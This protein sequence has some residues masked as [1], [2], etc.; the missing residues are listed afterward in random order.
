MILRKLFE[1][2]GYRDI[3]DDPG[4]FNIHYFFDFTSPDKRERPVELVGVYL[5]RYEDELFLILDSGKWAGDT[6]S[7]CKKWDDK[8]NEF[9]N[10]GNNSIACL[11]KFM[12]NMIQVILFPGEIGD[13]SEEASLK[14][15]RKVLLPYTLDYLDQICISDSDAIELPFYLGKMEDFQDESELLES[16]YSYVPEKNDACYEFLTTKHK[17][18]NRKP[19]VSEQPKTFSLK[20]HELIKGWLEKL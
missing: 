18:P 20:E 12:Y 8:L 7:L 17:H 16:L 10:F 13:R 9:C 15:S 14:T 11:H 19:N 4:T 5:S 6:S 3:L 2:Y 1:E